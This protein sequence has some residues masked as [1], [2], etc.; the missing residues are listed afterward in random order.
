MSYKLEVI[1][2]NIESCTVIEQSG[3][4]RIELCDNPHDGGSTAS[5]GMIK[6]ARE[7][8]SIQLFP[9]IRPRAGD[10][11]YSDDEFN[12]MKNDVQLC[13]QLRCDGVVLGLLQK[14]GSVDIKRT[15]KL[16]ELA[17]PMEVNFHRAFDRCRDPFEAL[18]Q[19]VEIG[20]QRILTS[21]Q[22]PLAT[23]GAERIAELV[24]DAAN[25][26]IIMPGSGVRPDNVKA[27]AQQTGAVEFHSSLR[28]KAET[29]MEFQ[30]PAFAGEADDSSYVTTD[31]DAIRN[32]LQALID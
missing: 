21:G 6:A 31:A 16:V 32:L 22:K 27:L 17:Y 15:A 26:I 24:K 23:E 12:I 10:F 19:L 30:Y 13:K 29:K 20:C 1:A 14:D 9:I 8:V 28:T 7:K 2:F 5:Y 25:R 4:H 11:L 3:A 18:E